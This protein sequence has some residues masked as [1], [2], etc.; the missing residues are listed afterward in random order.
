MSD[1]KSKSDDPSNTVDQ[2]QSTR[3]TVESVVVAFILA[4]LFR[5]FVAEAFVIPT[6]SMAPTLMGAHKDLFCEFCGQQYQAS[7][8]VEY[9]STSGA[10]KQEKT[11]ASTC[12][13]CRGINAYDFEGNPN[14]A[15]F[16]GDRILVSKFD[17]VLSRPERWD[18]FVFK[19]PGSARMN[20]IKRLVG[21]PGETLLISEGDVFV[22]N[23]D[24]AGWT[25]AR[26]PPHKIQA[27]K[28]LVHNTERQPAILVQQGWPSLWQPWLPDGN[29][30]ASDPTSAAWNIE[31]T[32]SS[33]S[34]SLTAQPAEH[35]LRY[36]HKFVELETWEDLKNGSRL[37]VIDPLS[38]Q[39]ITDYV[40]Y[41]TSYTLR[42]AAQLF[43]LKRS[44]WAR[45]LPGFL[46]GGPR[47]V[48]NEQK[49]GGKSV[50]EIA[51][52]K[53]IIGYEESS[54]RNDGN[55][56][57]GDLSG[58]FAVEIQSDSGSLLLSLVEF[59]IHFQCSI[60]VATGIAQLQALDQGNALDVFY[61]DSLREGQ[62]PIRGRGSY[63][64]EFANFDDQLV[65]WINRKV[66][67]FAGGTEFDLGKYRNGNSR[68]PHWSQ[69]DPLD[70]A[71]LGIGARDLSIK[72]ASSQVFRDIYYISDSGRSPNLNRFVF[73]DYMIDRRSLAEAVPDVEARAKLSTGSDILSAIYSHPQWW[74]STNL[75]SK[76]LSEQFD[77]QER[78]YFPL[79]DNSAASS[80]ARFWDESYVEE[81][82]LL[83]KALLVFWPHTWNSPIPFTPNIQRMGLIR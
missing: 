14:Q 68:R 74:A 44:P 45:F 56:W 64:I 8:S 77:L 24:E 75:F 51:R 1:K 39:L 34:A 2:V 33:W 13:N 70:A 72:V 30:A 69:A 55:H 41:N 52:D 23:E 26:K 9:D 19:Y 82:F 80:D 78:Q 59:G 22:Q 79:G 12:S 15:T 83:G 25:I 36:Y 38:S 66:V 62:T 71:P 3:E 37:P 6:G 47:W 29:A 32:E 20:Y 61:G 27:M 58:R 43:D 31:H 73:S 10:L 46:S 17:Y 16:S 28:Q 53:P 49:T 42:D 35:W 21:L 81:K 57:V 5:A 48:L 54:S 50:F 65:L 67:P 4:F 11:F 76:R 7:A 63:Q 60:D 18:V 40:A